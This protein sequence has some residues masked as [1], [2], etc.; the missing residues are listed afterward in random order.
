IPPFLA[1]WMPAKKSVKLPIVAGRCS[2]QSLARCRSRPASG[3]AL[4]RPAPSAAS[5]AKTCWRK[6]RRGGAPVEDHVADRNAAARLGAGRGAAGCAEHPEGQ[7]LQRELG[8]QVGRGHP[9]LACAIMGFVDHAEPSLLSRKRG[10]SGI[11]P[12]RGRRSAN[13]PKPNA[14]AMKPPTTAIM[15]TAI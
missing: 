12:R 4:A 1:W 14:R 8:M 3:S 9:A 5:S 7:V 10:T 11:E 13:N 6:A 15:L 2:Q